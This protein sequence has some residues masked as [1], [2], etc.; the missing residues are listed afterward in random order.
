MMVTV[1]MTKEKF[2]VCAC[3]MLRDFHL[4]TL[5][6]KVHVATVHSMVIGASSSSIWSTMFR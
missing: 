1:D 2:D 4:V 5:G 3:L 6:P